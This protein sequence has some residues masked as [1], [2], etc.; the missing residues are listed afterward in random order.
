MRK[1]IRKDFE[2]CFD[3]STEEILDEM[4]YFVGFATDHALWCQLEKTPQIQNSVRNII[5]SFNYVSSQFDV[6]PHVVPC[7]GWS[8]ETPAAEVQLVFAT[9]VGIVRFSSF[10]IGVI[11]WFATAPTPASIWLC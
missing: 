11:P 3:R 8:P 2:G 5:V 1:A 6:R 10:P 7:C 9:V 4:V